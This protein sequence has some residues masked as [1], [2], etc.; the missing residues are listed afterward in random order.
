MHPYAHLQVMISSATLFTQKASLPDQDH[1][2]LGSGMYRPSK[3]I[4]EA[5]PPGQHCCLSAG[6]T[7]PHC[8]PAARTMSGA[9]QKDPSELL[10][11]LDS[12]CLYRIEDWWTYEL[13][14]KKHVRQFH[15][16]C[17]HTCPS[18]PH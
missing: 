7:F 1:S 9:L 6:L 4:Q 12:L 5:Y 16:V 2:A 8:L 13:C 18:T 14:Y 17:T 3:S 10:S 15:K 11:A